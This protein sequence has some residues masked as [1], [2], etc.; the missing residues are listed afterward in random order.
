M[1]AKDN[2]RW[3]FAGA[4]C[5][6]AYWLPNIG[7]YP[8]LLIS[9]LIYC[10]FAV[11]F[12][13]LL[14]Y[15][16]LLSLGHAAFFGSGGYAAGYM[17]IRYE[18][19]PEVALAVAIGV[20]G[21]L[22][23]AIGVMAVRRTG[24][25]FAMITL[26]F[27]QLIYFLCVQLG[28]TG[29]EDG[30][31]GI[32]RGKLFGLLDLRDDVI[33]YRVVLFVALAVILGSYRVIYS[34]FGDMLKA[35]RDAEDRVRSL[36]YE[37]YYYKVMLFVLSAAVT[38]LAGALKAVS[39]GSVT[40]SDVHWLASG[41][42]L[43]MSLV[44]G[45]GYLLGPVVGAVVIVLLLNRAEGLVDLVSKGLDLPRMQGGMVSVLFILGLFLIVCALGF[46]K[47]IVGWTVE[48]VRKRVRNWT[49]Q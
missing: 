12:H 28:F 16:G 31:Q 32:T 18:V 37:S 48:V 49:V 10:I 42:P 23:V 4:V 5:T 19:S 47:G 38:S 21:L 2:L 43:V 25:Y 15:G 24:I 7:V 45:V 6:V 33:L 11:G 27:A 36:G 20:G 29:G 17:I 41:D 44:G 35:I 1:V 34:P 46:R 14:G 13:L 9:I 26:G 40:L 39:Q 22:G 3:L 30:L 8:I